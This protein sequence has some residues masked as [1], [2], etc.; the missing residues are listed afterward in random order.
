MANCWGL[1]RKFIIFLYGEFF[2]EFGIHSH[3]HN[4]SS[5]FMPLLLKIVTV[6]KLFFCIILTPQVVFP[7]LFRLL[8]DHV[9]IV[10]RLEL[11]YPGFVRR[12][13]FAI[14]ARAFEYRS[15]IFMFLR[16]NVHRSN[17]I[18]EIKTFPQN[19]IRA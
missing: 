7:S 1:L 14:S 5:G 8:P 19:K 11:G 16:S 3:W 10:Q 18:C 9:L 13:N 2:T 17:Y 4:N 12:S 15:Q 6:N